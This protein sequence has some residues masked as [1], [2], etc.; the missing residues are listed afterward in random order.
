MRVAQM[1]FSSIGL[2]CRIARAVYLQRDHKSPRVDSAAG[3]QVELKEDLVLPAG[4]EK[5]FAYGESFFGLEELHKSD[6]KQ[7][8]ILWTA[9]L[10]RR[11]CF[12][13]PGTTRR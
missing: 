9:A 8:A 7:R 3:L 5:G 12:L 1:G 11:F 2:P 10:F 6:R 13:Q 4:F